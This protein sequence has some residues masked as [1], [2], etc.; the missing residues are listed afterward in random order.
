[1]LFTCIYTRITTK[2]I[3]Y[4]LLGNFCLFICSDAASWV[5]PESVGRFQGEP[6]RS[7][8]L[9]DQDHN[10]GNFVQIHAKKRDV[11]TSTVDDE[12]TKFQVLLETMLLSVGFFYKVDADPP[13]V[14]HDT[15]SCDTDPDHLFTKC[16]IPAFWTRVGGFS[17][18]SSVQ[19]DLLTLRHSQILL[20]RDHVT[21]CYIFLNTD[22]SP[23]KF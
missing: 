15:E 17:W 6:R 8:Y 23:F 7:G 22:L 10:S 3:N 9:T 18:S 21:W 20:G 1:M 11:W 12:A 13:H 19:T 4:F 5:C 14:I 16:E 2:F